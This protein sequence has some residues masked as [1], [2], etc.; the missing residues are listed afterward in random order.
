MIGEIMPTTF[1]YFQE[2]F[3]PLCLLM[4]LRALLRTST[5]RIPRRAGLLNLLIWSVA[6]ILI[7]APGMTIPIA[8]RL[9]INRGADLIIYVAILGGIAVSFYFYQ[10]FRRMENLITELVRRDAVARGVKG[11]GENASP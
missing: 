4:A 7:T 11:G 3:V 2:I 5:G 8:N 6:A 9:G 10:R 1:N